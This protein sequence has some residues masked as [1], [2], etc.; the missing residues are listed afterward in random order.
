M[1]RNDVRMANAL[2][3]LHF[4]IKFVIFRSSCLAA[5]PGHFNALLLVNGLPNHFIGTLSQD[6]IQLRDIKIR[7]YSR[8]DYFPVATIRAAPL[9]N[10]LGLL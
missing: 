9:D 1:E 2:E 10:P 3:N 5:V 4:F 7:P 6:H 8:L